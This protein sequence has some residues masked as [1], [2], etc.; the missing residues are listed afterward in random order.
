MNAAEILGYIAAFLTTA[1]FIPQAILVIRT[2]RTAGISLMMYSMFVCGIAFWLACGIIIAA[3]P[4]IIANAITLVLAGMILI[5][6]MKERF[7]R[8]GTLWAQPGHASLDS[9]Q[10]PG[11]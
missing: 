3:L 7:A 4:I 1:S 10:K 8:R 6:A 9:K 5:I 11:P 2:R